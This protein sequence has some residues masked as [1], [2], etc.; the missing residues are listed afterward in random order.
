MAAMDLDPENFPLGSPFEYHQ[1]PT[2][3]TSHSRTRSNSSNHALFSAPPHQ[4]NS[5]LDVDLNDPDAFYRPYSGQSTNLPDIF[6]QSEDQQVMPPKR[7]PPIVNGTTSKPASNP[8]TLPRTT[9]RSASGPAASVR[10]QKDNAISTGLGIKERMKLLEQKAHSG[11][12]RPASSSKPPSSRSPRTLSKDRAPLRNGPTY[13]S[14]RKRERTGSAKQPLFGEVVD[15]DSGAGYGIPTLNK[16]RSNLETSLSQSAGS[17]RSPSSSHNRSS[18]DGTEIEVDGTSATPSPPPSRIPVPRSRRASDLGPHGQSLRSPAA[19]HASPRSDRTP[20]ARTPVTLTSHR[21]SPKRRVEANQTLTAVIKEP[22]PKLSPPLRSSRTRQS[23]TTTST[24]ASRARMNDRFTKTAT[25][26]KSVSRNAPK[27][28]VRVDITSR[29]EQVSNKLSKTYLDRPKI[30][31]SKSMTSDPSPES[32]SFPGA[33]PPSPTLS[34]EDA[35]AG[36][37]YDDYHQ[38]EQPHLSKEQEHI[39]SAANVP[40]ATNQV[41]SPHKTVSQ[42]PPEIRTSM[43]GPKINGTLFSQVLTMRDDS[44]VS[45]ETKL[46]DDLLSEKDDGETVHFVMHDTPQLPHENFV[47]PEQSPIPELPEDDFDFPGGRHSIYPDDSISVVGQ[48]RMRSQQETIPPVPELPKLNTENLRTID[49]AARSE[50]NRVLEQY[51]KGNVTPEMVQEFR[52]QVEQLTPNMAQHVNW[53]SPHATTEFFQKVLGEDESGRPLSSTASRSGRGQ[54]GSRPVSI[55]NDLRDDHEYRGTAIIF[56]NDSATSGVTSSNATT[57]PATADKT[58]FIPHVHDDRFSN[59]FPLPSPLARSFSINHPVEPSQGLRL[60]I[61]NNLPSRNSTSISPVAPEHPPPPPPPVPRP[62]LTKIETEPLIRKQTWGLPPSPAPRGRLRQGTMETEA[63]TNRDSR[64]SRPSIGT[65]SPAPRQSSDADAPEQVTKAD[66]D[67]KTRWNILKE[68]VDTE[69]KYYY[70]MTILV[71]IFMATVPSVSSLNPDDRRIIFGNAEKVR[72]ISSRFLEALKKAVHAV[73]QIPQENRFHMKRTSTE[74]SNTRESY[75]TNSTAGSMPNKDIHSIQDR[76]TN[77]GHLFLQFAEDMHKVYRTY[78]INHPSSN[79]KLIAF[80]NDPQVAL[81]L[82]ECVLTSK[83][84]TDVWSLDSMTIKPTQR[85]LKYHL[86]L[87]Q[88]IDHTPPDHPDY[89]DLTKSFELY[90]KNSEN[91]N[92]EAKKREFTEGMLQKHH[93]KDSTRGFNIKKLMKSRNTGPGQ[94]Q[95]RHNSSSGGG[96]YTPQFSADDDSYEAIRQK[97]GGHFFQLQIVMRDFEK[98]LEDADIHLQRILRWSVSVQASYRCDPTSR[99]TEVESRI[100]E[101]SELVTSIKTH[102]FPEHSAAV[103][104]Y[105]IDPVRKLW[106]LHDNPQHLMG[107]HRKLKTSFTRYQALKD[108][109]DKVNEKLQEDAENWMTINDVLTSELP[110]LY[111]LTKET[112][113]ACLKNF[114]EIQCR[115]ESMWIEKLKQFVGDYDATLFFE[116]DMGLFFNA[117]IKEYRQDAEEVKTHLLTMQF[118]QPNGPDFENLSLH[119]RF[120][121]PEGYDSSPSS[122]THRPSYSSTKRTGTGLTVQ[123]VRGSVEHAARSTPNLNL[124]T[125]QTGDTS[126]HRLSDHQPGFALSPNFGNEYPGLY[127]APTSGGPTTPVHA[128]SHR[129]PHMHDQPSS[130]HPHG[131]PQYHQD[132]SETPAEIHIPPGFN[133]HEQRRAHY[134][135]EPSRGPT[136]SGRHH[137]RQNSSVNNFTPAVVSTT[138]R[139]H[140]PDGR[141]SG[142][143]Q[144]ALP[145]DINDDDQAFHL[146]SRPSLDYDVAEAHDYQRHSRSMREDPVDRP[147]SPRVLFVVASLFEF[148]IDSNRREAGFPYLKYVAGEVFDIVGQKGELWLARNQ[149]DSNGTLGWIWEKHF[150]LLPNDGN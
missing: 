124:G 47:A 138:L 71:D 45:P 85:Y 22:M 27:D 119:G 95:Q 82:E 11:A 112:V 50:I 12:S 117:I 86:L 65:S 63:S 134:G 97:F 56:T 37:S 38:D 127:S 116:S 29:R 10:T 111:R 75:L 132:W 48:Q 54:K 41:S 84:I 102:A 46:P 35:N 28:F 98:Y 87:K 109:K 21:Y 104:K 114:L 147:G 23:A 83:D 94:P 53:D 40:I 96:A 9:Y 42:E 122:S 142:I 148:H 59:D 108:K 19:N 52:E 115:W 13:S 92:A 129:T 125:P 64:A 39:E 106:K 76:K 60:T 149:D 73:Y 137:T 120:P 30:D 51:Q 77:V 130:S 7:K 20:R 79:K 6:I 139:D 2:P 15:E 141:Y 80:K 143:F 49:S 135:R 36:A 17:S 113:H 81:W 55:K 123:S 110:E 133:E 1:Q 136:T 72:E 131:R 62:E 150:A 8:P 25:I 121:P 140:N 146:Q 74:T 67:L 88:L 107:R 118:C 34:E 70:D 145:A 66:Q 91:I 103:Q 78:M 4:P 57:R 68:L 89:E 100:H 58:I 31:T 44:P 14:P 3:T 144:S 126:L 33:F 90:T 26:D 128:A 16:A 5:S 69:H 61:D 105:V 101:F 18:S 93:Q 32:P 43:E 99:F 24:A